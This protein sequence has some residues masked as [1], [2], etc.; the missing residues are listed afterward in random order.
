MT[1]RVVRQALQILGL[2]LVLV[3]CPTNAEEPQK[4]PLE[5]YFSAKMSQWGP[6]D[7]VRVRY[8]IARIPLQDMAQALEEDKGGNPKFWRERLEAWYKK[9]KFIP[10]VPS[11]TFD[12]SSMDFKDSKEQHTWGERKYRHISLYGAAMWWQCL[13]WQKERPDEPIDE[14]E[15]LNYLH[16]Q[17]MGPVFTGQLSLGSDHKS[18]FL[19]LALSYTPDPTKRA[20]TT[21]P[22][23]PFTASRVM[24][25]PWNLAIN[26][27]FPVHEVVLFGAQMEPSSLGEIHSGHVLAA[28]GAIHPP[29]IEAPPTTTK[30]RHDDD[31]Q[32][33]STSGA[34]LHTWTL[35]VPVATGL[36][37]ITKRNNANNDGNTFHQ[38]LAKSSAPSDI[39]LLA[40]SSLALA[41]GN[42]QLINSELQWYDAAGFENAGTNIDWR[43]IP[44]DLRMYSLRHSMELDAEGHSDS[45][46]TLGP[47]DPF[48]AIPLPI[49]F[50]AP[51]ST[52]VSTPWHYDYWRTQLT[53]ARPTA[54][55]RWSKW[56]IAME[57]DD[58]DPDALEVAEASLD[59]VRESIHA[60]VLSVGGQVTLTGSVLFGDRMHVTFQRVAEDT[61]PKAAPASEKP[62]TP[63]S[64]TMT[65]WIIETP[66]TWQPRL[67]KA[68]AAAMTS[69]ASDLLA[70]MGS[71]EVKLVGQL[72]SNGGQQARITRPCLYLDGSLEIA[73]STR[74]VFFKGRVF[75]D[76]PIGDQWRATLVQSATPGDVTLESF[77]APEWQHWGVWQPSI[78]ATN[79]TNSG[80]ELPVFP[81]CILD[82]QWIMP[83][84]KPAVI[85]ALRMAEPGALKPKPVRLR[86]YVARLDDVPAR[87]LP[88]GDPDPDFGVDLFSWQALVLRVNKDEPLAK[89]KATA[90]RLLS[91]AKDDKREVLELVTLH[92][93]GSLKATFGSELHFTNG[94]EQGIEA[95]E[96]SPPE[97]T[98]AD[99]TLQD[100]VVGFHLEF[101]ANKLH[102]KVE[103]DEQAPKMVTDTFP[104]VIDIYP[105]R[106][107]LPDTRPETKVSIQRPIFNIARKEFDSPLP[108]AGDTI[109]ERLSTTSVVI[110]RRLP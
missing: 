27:H 50:T 106:Q 35:S 108:Q 23:P 51:P 89:D 22:C 81:A 25:R 91:E 56:K 110:I 32:S 79:A 102:W 71:D 70:S 101:D 58:H 20:A 49:P 1:S 40:T 44:C 43:P 16:E 45:P 38:W 90:Q 78:L 88:N 47:D 98:Y 73:A 46:Q 11:S 17:P 96:P 30:P 67:L 2:N 37:W 74:G 77:G 69:L 94:R 31:P 36:P 80:M 60:D 42:R 15:V 68:D 76:K 65:Y 64:A 28:F 59:D 7:G 21:W 103:R 19:N 86:W 3:L 4:I 75:R 61:P 97:G 52:A 48:A 72:S 34:H 6:Q 14:N 62:S 26:G 39:E 41:S 13:T 83:C 33:L 12:N 92:H 9:G 104:W 66:M 10:V 57:R 105:D 95:T 18:A 53:V 84:G 29:A 85:A 107:Q 87:R 100:H 8:M 99:S 55:V 24:F 109:F 5:D 54:P 63:Q 82:G 93:T